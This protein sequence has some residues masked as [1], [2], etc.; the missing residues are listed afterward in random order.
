MAHLFTKFDPRAFLEYEEP[1]SDRAKRADLL[2]PERTVT[3]ATLAGRQAETR[4]FEPARHTLTDAREEVAAIAEHDGGAP[5]DWAEALVRLD[6]NKPPRDV[7]PQRWVRFLTDAHAFLASDWSCQAR[8]LGWSA[9]DLFGCHPIAPYARHDRHGL[10]LSF[11]ECGGG[12]L[13]AMTGD[14]AVIERPTGSHQ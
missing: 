11:G 1:K 9:L 6:R 3:L 13:V 2:E 8:E 7:P 12:K 4:N 10:I 14:T 5:Q